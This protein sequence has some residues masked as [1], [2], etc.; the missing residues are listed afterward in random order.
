[1]KIFKKFKNRIK[2]RLGYEFKGP[3]IL[4]FDDNKDLAKAS[5]EFLQRQN[6]Q[7]DASHDHLYAA[8]DDPY[9]ADTATKEIINLMNEVA[10]RGCK[11]QEI[12][13][14]VWGFR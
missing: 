12:H 2:P 10:P 5:L 8:L 4:A 9:Y 14:H 6:I 1:M 11:F 3:A 7:L 13:P